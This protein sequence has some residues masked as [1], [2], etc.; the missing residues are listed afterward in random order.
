MDFQI[1]VWV[2]SNVDNAYWL[3]KYSWTLAKATVT[4]ISLWSGPEIFKNKFNFS[5]WL[6]FLTSVILQSVLLQDSSAF[7]VFSDMLTLLFWQLFY[8]SYLHDF[9]WKQIPLNLNTLHI[10][11]FS[12]FSKK[13]H[14]RYL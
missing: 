7:L 1:F 9:I 3:Q 12:S 4:Q 2:T 14:H 13:M 5:D 11:V 8:I 10:S 6:F